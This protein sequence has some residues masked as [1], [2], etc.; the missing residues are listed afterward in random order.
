MD[1]NW[2]KV[3]FLGNTGVG[4]TSIIHSRCFDSF[5]SM[6]EPTIN[7]SNFRTN[8]QLMNSEIELRLWDTAGQ[9]QYS[10]LVPLYCRDIKVCVLV[11]DITSKI[12][13]ESLTKWQQTVINAS[14]S[15]AFVIAI[16]KID[17]NNQHKMTNEEV[18]E[19]MKRNFGGCNVIFVSAL[20]GEG[21]D[22]LFSV[23]ARVGL[24][25]AS[26]T[27]L[28]NVTANVEL[29]QEKQCKC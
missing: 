14:E 7:T 23:I 29:K 1:K 22:S 9:E 15:P 13:I 3:I 24:N 17:L 8:V 26:G 28:D 21:I 2:I 12:S 20:T 4:K 10:S 25:N 18:I 11:A 5:S 16:N 19:Y 6:I 27:P